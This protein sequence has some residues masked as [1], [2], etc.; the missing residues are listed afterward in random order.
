[1]YIDVKNIMLLNLT[2][3]VTYADYLGEGQFHFPS[4]NYQIHLIQYVHTTPTLA[5]L[6]PSPHPVTVCLLVTRTDTI[7]TPLPPVPEV[8][9]ER[10]PTVAST[11]DVV[12]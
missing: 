1:M 11:D 2:T 4:D 3:L 6:S 10:F 12:Q 5:Q 9:A 7:Y 8:A